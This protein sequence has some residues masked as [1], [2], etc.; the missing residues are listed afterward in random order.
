WAAEYACGTARWSL[1]R[2]AR[3]IQS[4]GREC[5]ADWWRTNAG[6]SWTAGREKARGQRKRRDSNACSTV[7]RALNKIKA[8]GP[9]FFGAVSR[10]RLRGAT[11]WQARST[12]ASEQFGDLNGVERRALEQLIA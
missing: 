12:S 2:R 1:R 7:I 3:E 9:E 10:T 5:A 4:G 8:N 6:R 11:A